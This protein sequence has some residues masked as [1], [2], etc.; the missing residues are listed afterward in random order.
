MQMTALHCEICSDMCSNAFS[1]AY[2]GVSDGEC[3]I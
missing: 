2:T 3:W 1:S